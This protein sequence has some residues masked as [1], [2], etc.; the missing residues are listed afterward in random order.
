MNKYILILLGALATQ[1]CNEHDPAS[2][3]AKSETERL[4]KVEDKAMEDMRN[5]PV[6]DAER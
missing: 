5:R 3:E 1:S 2:N 6:R 4:R